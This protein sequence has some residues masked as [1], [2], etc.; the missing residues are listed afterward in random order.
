MKDDKLIE[1]INLLSQEDRE[2]LE[3]LILRLI[4]Y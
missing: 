2:M 1:I 4:K 3:N